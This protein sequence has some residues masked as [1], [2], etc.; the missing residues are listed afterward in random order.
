[1]NFALKI[2]PQSSSLFSEPSTENSRKLERIN[3]ILRSLLTAPA[4]YAKFADSTP[5]SNLEVNP[6]HSRKTQQTER[7]HNLD[8]SFRIFI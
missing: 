2:H 7:S 4:N 6:V 8:R 3:Q 1:M 5:I